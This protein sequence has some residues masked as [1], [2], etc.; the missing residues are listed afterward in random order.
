MNRFFC[1]KTYVLILLLFISAVMLCA[2]A[3]G[4]VRA[5]DKGFSLQYARGLQMQHHALG[6]LVT[7]HPAWD[8]NESAVRYLLVPRGKKITVKDPALQIITVPVRRVVSLSTTHLAYIDAAGCTD[9]LVGLADFKHVNTPS[10]I[11]RIEAGNVKAVGNFSNLR[12]ETIM[13]LSPDLILTSASG[14]IYDSHPKLMEAGLPTVMVIDHMEAHPL[15]RLE[16]IKFLGLLLGTDAHACQL[17]DQTVAEYKQL[18]EKTVAVSKRPRV[19][20]GA[21]FQGHWWVARGGSF[22]AR[23]IRDAGGDY[24]WANIPGVSSVPMDIESVY[25]RALSADVWINTGSWKRVDESLAADPRFGI[26][27][28][29]EKGRMVNNNKRLNRWGGNDYWESGMLHPEV[30]LADLI[31]ILHPGLLT[32]HKLV[33]YRRLER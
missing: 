20:T 2:V 23:Y 16:W 3:A 11:Q 27:P 12:I 14:S 28:A 1:C 9:R 5:D 29:L 19:L 4:V 25:E 18:V 32:D 31:A 6:I 13:D 24:L 22:I 33:Y 17:F 21:P 15:G 7:I 30:V 10:V 8:K 26:I